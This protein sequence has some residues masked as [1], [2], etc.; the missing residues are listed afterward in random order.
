MKPLSR[1]VSLLCGLSMLAGAAHAQ[2]AERVDVGGG[3]VTAPVASGDYLYVGTGTTIGVWSLAAPGAP[4]YV[5]RTSAAPTPGPIGA[6]AQ[7]G[8]YL[9]AAWSTTDGRGGLTIYS[10]AE[11]GVPVAVAEDDDYIASDYKGPTGLATSGDYVFVG[12]TQNGLVVLDASDPLAP[13]TVATA[14]G[15]LTFDA[16]AVF[17][18]QLVTTGSDWVGGR[19]VTVVDITDPTAPVVAGSTSL[20]GSLVLRAVPTDG[21]AIGVGVDLMV[22]DLH[23]PSNITQ[24]FDAPIDAATG[25]IRDGD[26]LYLVGDSGIQVWDFSTP[27]A[28]SLLRTIPA[29]TF[30]PDQATLTSFGPLILTHTDRGVLLD[31]TDPQQPSVAAEFPLPIGV[32]AHS[33]GF[34]AGHVYFAEEGYGLGVADARTLAPVGRFDADLPADLVE[35]DFEDI[36]VDN[37]RAYLAAWG[38]GVI[39]V[40]LADPAAPTELGRFQLPFASAIEAHGELVYTA[41]ATNGGI[42]DLVD[43]SDPTSPALLGQLT[44]DSVYDL[45]VRGNYA[46]LGTGIGSGGGPGGLNIVDVSDP[47]APTVVGHEASCPYIGGI[48]VSA[49]GTR[50]YVACESDV[51][52]ANALQILD[53]TDKTNPVLIGSIALPGSESLPDFNDAHAVA[54][55]GTTAFVGNEFGVDEV[56]VAD[57]AA[58][59]W[60]ARHDTGFATRRVQIAPDGRIFALTQVAGVHV[61]QTVDADRIFA[62]GFDG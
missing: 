54:V 8:G 12:D 7:V 22:Y 47:T 29:P 18:T 26:T 40:D 59:V 14:S 52:Y 36:S 33:A 21:Y 34:D 61:L 15:V 13:T 55:S 9:Y 49:D 6:L 27:S 58:P 44:T 10:L 11:P 5:G 20:D 37:G 17:G 30:A 51:N 42:F 45:T 60:V 28:P 38:Y 31:T 57:A 43:F 4:A 46:Y 32:A 39:A 19:D 24:L 62:D 3:A 23:D 25:A 35:R 56:D 1:V 16:M 41:T 53:T 48:D 2:T 50:T